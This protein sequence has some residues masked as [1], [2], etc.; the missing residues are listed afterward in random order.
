VYAFYPQMASRFHIYE[1][2]LA[3][4][5]IVQMAAIAAYV[6]AARSWSLAPVVCLGLAASLGLLVR[7]TGLAFFGMWCVLLAIECRSKKA[8]IAFG[9]AT[10][11]LFFFWLWSNHVKTGSVVG[12]GLNNAM[13]WNDYHTPMQRF[14]SLCS[15]SPGH[16]WQAAKRLA[17]ALFLSVPQNPTSWMEK[18]HFDLEERPGASREPFLGGFVAAMLAW[19]LLHMLVRRERRLQF[20]VP[21]ATIVALFGAYAAAAGGFAWRYAGDF[22]PLIVLAAVQYVRWL[23]SAASGLFGFRL[24]LVLAI[25]SYATY[26][27]EVEPHLGVQEVLDATQV[28][29]LSGD[30][31]KSL[32]DV[33]LPMPSKIQCGAVP[34]W[35]WHNGQGWGSGCNV[36]TFT[37]VFV[38]VPEKAQDGYELRLATA[39][40]A[41]PPSLRVYLNGRIYTA[42]REGDSYVAHVQVDRGRLNSPVVMATIEW[43]RGFDRP[44]GKLLSIELV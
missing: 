24:A 40:M 34:S 44:A 41:G 20:Y 43:V 35:P 9:A 37:N 23:P 17:R 14:G 19:M 28:A 36:D 32:R 1:E 16:A 3:Y 27:R 42:A 4:F 18:C 10:A 29:S 15:D 13:P 7:A 31:Q 12:I 30:F 25:T 11:P 33:D 8:W 21:L 22:W 5:M 39:G 38:G 2:T 26:E 6:F